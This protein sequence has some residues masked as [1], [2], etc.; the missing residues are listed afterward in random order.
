MNKIKEPQQD[1]NMVIKWYKD[2][3]ELENASRISLFFNFGY[4]SLKIHGLNA[5]R[6]SGTYTCVATNLSGTAQETARL[7]I[8]ENQLNVIT[9]TNVENGWDQIQRLESTRITKHEEIET[10]YDEKPKF[11]TDFYGKTDYYE[12]QV[13]M[14]E[15]KFTPVSDPNLKVEIFKN[16]QPLEHANRISIFHGFGYV[17]LKI[18]HLNA[19]RD[20]GVYTAVISNKVGS[21]KV[22]TRLNVN[23]RRQEPDTQFEEGLKKIQQLESSTKYRRE[24]YEEVEIREKPRFLVP[25]SNQRIHEYERAYFETRL[26][27]KFLILFII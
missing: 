16:N 26:G 9:N 6:D 18:H 20:S 27:M 3:V 4:V 10:E 2:G 19:H 8:I 17:S 14:F 7:T 11:L 25:L 1:Q 23:V 5:K 13:A 21:D 15:A 12:E 22:S 24:E